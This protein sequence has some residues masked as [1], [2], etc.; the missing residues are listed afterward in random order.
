MGRFIELDSLISSVA[1]QMQKYRHT[2]TDRQLDRMLKRFALCMP[3]I[4]QYF[5]ISAHG[6][7]ICFVFANALSLSAASCLL[8]AAHSS[9]ARYSQR[10]T[11][12]QKKMLTKTTNTSNWRPLNLRA[13]TK[14]N[15]TLTPA[16]FL[17]LFRFRLQP[18]DTNQPTNRPT[19][20]F[21][22]RSND[23]VCAK[24]RSSEENTRR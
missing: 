19:D 2:Q 24:Q 9:R 22:R 17:A 12:R 3:S 7:S 14:P 6:P 15:T 8:R 10:P 16:T 23:C 13:K 11:Q 1:A 4:G 18:D 20:H 21:C 5:G